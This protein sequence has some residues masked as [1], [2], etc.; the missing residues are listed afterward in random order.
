L[1]PFAVNVVEVAIPRALVVD[2]VLAVPLT[3]VP[4]APLAGALKVT[5]APEIG[6]PW[7][8]VTLADRVWAKAVLTGA[9]WGVPL[10]ALIVVAGPVRLVRAN[11]A[12]AVTPAT[13]AVTV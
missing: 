1:V 13:V 9:L 7:A 8:S 11:D 10:V 6:F 2:E 5:L 3:K 12:G 4:L